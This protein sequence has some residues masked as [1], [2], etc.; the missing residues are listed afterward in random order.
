ML[1][2]ALKLLSTLVSEHSAKPRPPTPERLIDSAIQTSPGLE[3]ILQENKLED[4][5]LTCMSNN[6]EHSQAE[7]FPQ[8]PSCIIGKRK[9]TLRGH[10]RRTKRPLVLS[11][12]SKRTV[13]DE[14][15]QPLMTCNNQQ[16]V[17]SPLCERRDLNTVSSQVGLNPDSLQ[18]RETRSIGAGCF[19]TPLSCW[20]QDSNSSVCLA[21]MEPM[22]ERLSAESKTRRPV[23]PEGFWQL[24]DMDCD[25]GF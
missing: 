21:G 23:K 24:F 13:T 9:F 8:D 2:E 18:N 6:R 5:Q 14:N 20:S 25:S 7:A 12:R 19:I 15:S 10:K 17:S 11:Q 22:L 3:N 4:T 1:E 16:N